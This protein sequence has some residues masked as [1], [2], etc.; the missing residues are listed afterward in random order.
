MPAGEAFEPERHRLAEAAGARLE[1][2][3]LLGVY[4]DVP[5]L[6]VSRIVVEEE[7][8]RLRLWLKPDVLRGRGGGRLITLLVGRRVSDGKMLQAAL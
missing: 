2:V 7:G 3:T 4:P 6:A 5:I 8:Q 1:D